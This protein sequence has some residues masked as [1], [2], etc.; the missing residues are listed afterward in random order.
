[1]PTATRPNFDAAGR[2]THLEAIACAK[3][4]ELLEITT[5]RRTA[6]D[7]RARLRARIADLDATNIRGISDHEITRLSAR[8]ADVEDAI[9][10]LGER[11]AAATEV[12]TT[13]AH[14]FTRARDRARELG[15][16]IPVELEDV[17]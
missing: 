5:R 6:F 2:L 9:Q 8:L 14:T 3:H 13:A 4:H 16:A 10:R 11:E 1:M 7:D 17:K 15:L 12:W